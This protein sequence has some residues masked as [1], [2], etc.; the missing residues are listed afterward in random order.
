LR[1]LKAILLGGSAVPPSLVTRAL[2]AN[3]PIFTSYGLS[4]MGSQVTTTSP[5]DSAA[6]LGSSGKVLNYRELTLSL[7]SE[8]LVRGK[9]RFLGYLT[10]SGMERPFDRD[11]WFATG[12]L[13]AIDAD[14]YLTVLGRKDNLF[15]SGGENIQPEE[16]ER[17]LLEDQSVEEAIVVPVESAEFGFRPVA[18]VKMSSFPDH[19]V[20]ELL[21]ALRAKLPGYKIP[22]RILPWPGHLASSGFK[23]SRVALRNLAHSLYERS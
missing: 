21:E 11:G 7:E 18:F 19:E 16:V 17:A 15:V 9:T 12:D 10:D 13:G 2:E 5:N 6:R 8:I 1:T 23:P 4:E 20:P 3:L 14:G 22:D